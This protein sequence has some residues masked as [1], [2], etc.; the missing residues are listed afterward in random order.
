MT[1]MWVN[2]TLVYM[3]AL[4]ARYFSRPLYFG[5]QFIKPSKVLVFLV[6]T[7][8]VLVSGLRNN[9]GDTYFYMHSYSNTEF[10][11]SNIDFTGDFGFNLLQLFL[12]TFSSD[13][14]IL[15]LTTA[16][17]T[18]SLIVIALSK[19]SRIFELAVYV[20]ITSGMFTVSMNGIRQY[21]AAGIIFMATKYILN[22]NFKK[23]FFII[24]LAATFHK[25]ALVLLPI[26]FIVRRK[27]WSK[28]T[29]GLIIFSI[30]IVLGFNLFID[31]LFTSLSNTQYGHYSEFQ[32]GGASF[33]RLAVNTAPIL[34]AFLG[35]EKLRELWPKSDY[36]VNLS[37]I[38][39]LFLVIST[40][41]WIFA[42]FNIYF[43][44]YNLVLVSWLIVLFKDNS[45]KFIY[46]AILICYLIFF[47]YEQVISLNIVIESKYFNF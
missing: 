29:F 12:Q 40:Q 3:F 36:I 34:I 7:S 9:I 39:S 46:Y 4:L 43:G 23:Y 27:A 42:R 16:L 19:Y 20:Y 30:F 11:L 44:L 21:L 35:K 47:Y 37:I 15:I 5:S 2:L 10:S 38:S 32:E 28:V 18:N 26:Y 33:L 13:P 25:T 41:N 22:G 45:K 1:I 8:L 14:Q 17:I 31:L 24:L 6:I